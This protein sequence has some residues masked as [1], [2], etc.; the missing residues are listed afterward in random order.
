MDLAGYPADI[1][2]LERQ[3]AFG[4][5]QESPEFGV[6][7]FPAFLRL[8]ES[9]DLLQIIVFIPTTY[10][11]GRAPDLA[12]LLHLLNKQLEI[13]GFGMEEEASVIFYRLMIPFERAVDSKTLHRG[14]KVAEATSIA[15]APIITA[16]AQGAT[17]FHDIVQQ[18]KTVP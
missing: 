2:E 5:R 11:M 4:I 1:Q 3:L 9:G 18:Q 7:D 12:R 16:V 17:T 10:K 6:L 8:Y 15:F 14:I 13:P